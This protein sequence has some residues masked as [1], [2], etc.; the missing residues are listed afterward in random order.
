MSQES[1]SQVLKIS[2]GTLSKIEAGKVDP[3]AETL[4]ILARLSSK[5]LKTAS[6]FHNFIFNKAR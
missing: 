3:G 1:F 6:L 2:Q 5:K 4:V